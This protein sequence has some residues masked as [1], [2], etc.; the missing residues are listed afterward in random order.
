M[1]R[2]LFFVGA[3]IFLRTL[4]LELTEDAERSL[5][6]HGKAV[7]KDAARRRHNGSLRRINHV[8]DD[9]SRF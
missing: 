9:G 6:P 8:I 7:L 5:L 1:T 2:C 4:A 3:N